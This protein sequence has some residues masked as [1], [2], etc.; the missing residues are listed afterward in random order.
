MFF[1]VFLVLFISVEDFCKGNVM[2]DVNV[3]N[4]LVYYYDCSIVHPSLEERGRGDY[5]VGKCKILVFIVNFSVSKLACCL[6]FSAM[7]LLTIVSR[8]F[9]E[10]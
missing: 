5:F 4:N 2:K 10:T 8:S 9:E 6:D 3:V 1:E 7:G